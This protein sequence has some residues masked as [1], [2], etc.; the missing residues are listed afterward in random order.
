MIQH[1]YIVYYAL[2]FSKS[3]KK[4]NP[5]MGHYATSKSFQVI[6]SFISSND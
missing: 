4:K 5:N 1:M 3:K 6:F 2:C